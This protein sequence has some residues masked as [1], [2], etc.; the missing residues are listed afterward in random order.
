M[1]KVKLD[2]IIDSIEMQHDEAE[3][4]FHRKTGK[5]ILIYDGEIM[6]NAEDEFK[7]YPEWQ[8]ENIEELKEK[9]ETD[10]Y[11]ELPT[12]YAIHEYNI[13]KE[14]CLSVEDEDIKDKLLDAISG[15]GAFRMFKSRAYEYNILEKW[16]EYKNEALKQIA[17]DWCEENKIEFK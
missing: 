11:I 7:N 1:R 13:M 14:F 15:R 6:V 8:Q 9:F 16:Y 17:I 4:Y 12:K 3:Q 5:I 10:D 2:E